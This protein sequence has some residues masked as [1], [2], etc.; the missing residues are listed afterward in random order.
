MKSKGPGANG[1]IAIGTASIERAIAFLTRQGI[2]P[3]PN[4]AKEKNGK[5]VAIYLK[6]EIAGF[7]VHLLQR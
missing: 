7:A 6:D 5:L 1:H 3:D 2:K 4:S